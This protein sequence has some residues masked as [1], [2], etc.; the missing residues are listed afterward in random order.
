MWGK[1]RVGR[2]STA[3]PYLQCGWRAC[4]QWTVSWGRL[5]GVVIAVPVGFLWAW[6]GGEMDWKVEHVGGANGLVRCTMPL[7]GGSDCRVQTA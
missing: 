3:L 5:V 2:V 6:G 4:A 1:I 7:L